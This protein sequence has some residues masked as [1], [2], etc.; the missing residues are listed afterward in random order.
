MKLLAT[1]AT[2]AAVSAAYAATFTLTQTN[3][4]VEVPQ[5]GL[6]VLEGTITNNSAEYHPMGGGLQIANQNGPWVGNSGYAWLAPSGLN[7]FASYTGPIFQLGIAG[8]APLGLA[9][10]EINF[11]GNDPDAFDSISLTVVPEP[12]SVAAIVFGAALLARRKDRLRR[13]SGK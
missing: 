4:G 7:A 5:G 10:G 11:A 8:D 12:S 1:L 2:V 3:P 6:F 9:T 13:A